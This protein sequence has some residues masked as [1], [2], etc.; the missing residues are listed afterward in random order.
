MGK[1]VKSV[2]SKGKL[3]GKGTITSVNTAKSNPRFD[4]E[5]DAKYNYADGVYTKTDIK[6]ML[7]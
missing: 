1:R 6:K 5:W 7:L 4:V 2:D 3:T